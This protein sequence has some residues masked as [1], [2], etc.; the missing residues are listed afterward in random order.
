MSASSPHSRATDLRIRHDAD[1][2]S[3]ECDVD[4]HRCVID[5]HRVGSVLRIVHTGVPPAVEGRGIAAALVRFALDHARVNELPI[6]PHVRTH[7]G[8]RQSVDTRA[9][10]RE[11]HQ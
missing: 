11:A 3:F 10:A 8:D 1:R 6:D 7:R 9:V 2:S 4:G 5:Y